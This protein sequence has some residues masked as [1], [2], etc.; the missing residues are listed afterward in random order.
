MRALLLK[1]LLIKAYPS[2]LLRKGVQPS[3]ASVGRWNEVWGRSR[4]RFIAAG[5]V[6]PI[7]SVC[8]GAEIEAF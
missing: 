5:G 6:S 4:A 7:P 3:G 8:V 1:S 2:G